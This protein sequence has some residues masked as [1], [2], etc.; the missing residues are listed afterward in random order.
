MIQQLSQTLLSIAIQLG[1]LVGVFIVVGF[2]LGFLEKHSNRYLTK[3]FGRKGVLAT[4]WIGTPIHEL[5]HAIMCIIFRHKI[6]E[7]KLLQFNDPNG[8]LGYVHHSY[9]PNNLYQ[10]IGIFFIG[11]APVFSGIIALIVSMYFLVPDT[12]AVFK[13]YL[14][15][16]V[17]AGQIDLETIQNMLIACFSLWK[18]LF[19]L[20]HLMSPSFWFFLLL[21]ISISS[22]IA[23][24]RADMK[25]SFSGFIVIFLILLVFNTISGFMGIN[26]QELV[27]SITKYNVYVLAF[28][29]VAIVFSTFTLGIS[30]L[31][32]RL[33]ESMR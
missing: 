27:M 6:I 13:T 11:I 4:A 10:R 15:T 1:Y 22:H 31:I 9:N 21:A 32:Y 17:K 8:V 14:D 12:Y 30:Y 18:S 25:Q 26:S 2:L 7:I 3:S 23:L 28:S 29:S 33:K 24:S 19:S 20:S 16:E 5:G